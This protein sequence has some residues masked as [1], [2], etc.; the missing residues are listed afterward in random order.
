M[1]G[2]R[3]RAFPGGRRKGGG[4]GWRGLLDSPV[5]RRR[6]QNRIVLVA[7]NT[8]IVHIIP[9][10]VQSPYRVGKYQV[11]FCCRKLY[12]SKLGFQSN[13]RY[14]HVSDVCSRPCPPGLAIRFGLANV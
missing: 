12:E 6:T 2:S 1:G 14:V 9:T 8:Y 4:G 3:L 13:K 7:I 5:R 11:H 10:W